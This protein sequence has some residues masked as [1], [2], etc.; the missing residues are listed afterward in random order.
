LIIAKELTQLENG[1]ESLRAT[2]TRLS[3]RSVAE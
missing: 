1:K 3:S 2:R